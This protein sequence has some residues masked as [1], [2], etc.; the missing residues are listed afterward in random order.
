VKQGLLE[1]ALVTGLLALAAAAAL[2]LGGG[3]VRASLGL[4]PPAASTPAAG[5]RPASPV[6]AR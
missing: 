4:A 5:S 2:F 1:F 6:P 3:E